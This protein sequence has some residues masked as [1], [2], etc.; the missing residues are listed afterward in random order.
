M[1]TLVED[2]DTRNLFDKTDKVHSGPVASS[3]DPQWSE[4]T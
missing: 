2:F 4:K 3:L 1:G